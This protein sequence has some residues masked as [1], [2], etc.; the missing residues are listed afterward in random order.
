MAMGAGATSVVAASTAP[1]GL[2]GCQ[3][4]FPHPG[5]GAGPKPLSSAEF[6]LVRLI[7]WSRRVYPPGEL[8]ARGNHVVTLK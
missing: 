2:C 4:D 6:Q 1:P 5:A 7:H 8:C 3:G